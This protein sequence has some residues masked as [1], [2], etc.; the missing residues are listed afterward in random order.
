L[1]QPGKTGREGSIAGARDFLRSP[2]SGQRMDSDTIAAGGIDPPLPAPA[3]MAHGSPPDFC[4]VYHQL[5]RP[6]ANYLLRR[7]GDAHATEDLLGDVFLAVLRGLPR[8]RERGRPVRHWVFRIA[9]H[10]ANR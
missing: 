2:L 3:A 6:V 10:S 1:T 8:Y 7:T 9:N 5:Y 4:T